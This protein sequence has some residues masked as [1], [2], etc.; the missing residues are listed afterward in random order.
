MR[1]LKELERIENKNE[2]NKTQEVVEKTEV[3][4]NEEEEEWMRKNRDTPKKGTT[5]TRNKFVRVGRKNELHDPDAGD[6]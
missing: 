2:P 4:V 3:E 1:Y 6:V 5:S